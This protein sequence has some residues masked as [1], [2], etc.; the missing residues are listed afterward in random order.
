MSAFATSVV[1]V[2][3][4]YTAPEILL[5]YS[6]PSGAFS[7]A[8]TGDAQVRLGEGDQF[9]Y[10]K[11]LEMRGQA[12]AAQSGANVLPS[13]TLVPSLISI[14]TYLFQANA[15]YD[16]H[17]TASMSRWG[18][19]TVQAYRLAN[20]QIIFQQERNAYLY[21]INASNG[22]GLI[23][24]AGAT[25]ATLPADSFGNTTFGT[26]D[27][28][29]MAIYLLGLISQLL[30]NTYNLG[31]PQKVVILGPQRILRNWLFQ[32]IV[33]TTS[34]QRE[35]AGTA[36][37]GQVVQLQGATQGVEIVYNYDDTLQGKGTGGSTT[38]MVIITTPEIKRPKT[39]SRIDTNA[40]ASV[41]PGNLDVNL[42]YTDMAA[43]REWPTPIPGSGALYTLF[44]K[45]STPGWCVRPEGLTLLTGAP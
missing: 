21:G 31:V 19:D 42:M 30:S 26:Y 15:T 33:Q 43:P 37:T 24:T 6:Q 5:Q 36:A 3:P 38:D 14:P 28:G 35:G 12:L 23:N 2:E 4:N 34:Y 9:V 1:K 20:R 39:Q 25:N 44:E 27:N 32:G 10:I 41:T 8:A 7:T 13:A 11:K 16:F 40:F 17:E 22:E 29:Q 18:M 45:R